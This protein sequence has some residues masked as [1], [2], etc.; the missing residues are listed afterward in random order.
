MHSQLC[1]SMKLGAV[2]E[3]GFLTTKFHYLSGTTDTYD[4]TVILAAQLALMDL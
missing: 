4:A 1:T 2:I 3:H